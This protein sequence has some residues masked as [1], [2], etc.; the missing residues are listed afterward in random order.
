MAGIISPIYNTISIGIGFEYYIL[1]WEI[2]HFFISK[3]N[4]AIFFVIVEMTFPIVG[5]I[6][7]INSLILLSK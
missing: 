3:Y 2:S 1:W 5:Y 7:I 4:A 6:T